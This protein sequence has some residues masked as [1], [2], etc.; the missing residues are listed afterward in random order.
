MAGIMTDP[1]GPRPARVWSRWHRASRPG[2][3]TRWAMLR[4]PAY[5]L[6]V[7]GDRLSS[8]PVTQVFGHQAEDAE[9]CRYSAPI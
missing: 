6:E 1:R 7:Q 8:S 3:G 9:S 5:C 2:L 4:H